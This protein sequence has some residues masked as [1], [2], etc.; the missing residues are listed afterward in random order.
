MC[1]YSPT[2]YPTDCMPS[3]NW[4]EERAE[5][6]CSSTNDYGSANKSYGV[7]VCDDNNS[8]TKQ[9]NLA[10]SLA[11]NFY[12]KCTS[13]CVYDYDTVM[14]NIQSGSTNYG[15]FIWRNIDSCWKWVTGYQCFV[16]SISEFEE[17]SLRAEDLCD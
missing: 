14:N 6:L 8:V 5:E 3:Y 12:T 7:Q 17:V 13:W 15:G 1:I 4:N 11:N 2:L 10:K 16:G 9:T